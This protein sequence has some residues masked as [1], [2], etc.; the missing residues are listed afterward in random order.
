[1]FWQIHRGT[2][3]NVSAIA[4]VTRDMGG[5]LR[6]RLKE[7]KGIAGRQRVVPAPVQADV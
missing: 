6:V 7:R 5:H 1:M 2:V 4:G 3:V